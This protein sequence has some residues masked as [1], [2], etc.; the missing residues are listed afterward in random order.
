VIGLRTT[1][2]VLSVAIGV[3]A[4][5]AAHASVLYVDADGRGSRCS[6]TDPC[7]LTTGAGGAEP[8]DRVVLKRGR[9]KSN[10]F[11]VGPG[12]VLSGRGVRSPRIAV[13]GGYV[14]VTGSGAVLR[15]LRLDF[16]TRSGL[17]VS[18]AG[19]AE[20]LQIG[21]KALFACR[22]ETGAL[23]RDSVCWT[24]HVTGSAVFSWPES[25]DSLSWVR[26][27]TAISGYTGVWAHATDPDQEVV[28]DARN[29]I[30]RALWGGAALTEGIPSASARVDFASSN[31][32]TRYIS[33]GTGPRFVT[34]PGTAGNFTDPPAF[35][36]EDAGDFRQ[37]PGSP[38]VDRGTVDPLVGKV[39][40]GGGPRIQGTAPD[41]GAY[42]GVAR[43]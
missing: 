19:V 4:A 16:R 24:R 26:N 25:G 27:V 21:G 9:Y 10:G 11:A 31:Y 38:T 6:K 15:N 14:D 43:R 28:I 29:V 35:L 30:S 22:L 42:E 41:V 2:V 3:V 23:I 5:G 40:L 34:E 18:Q 1:L 8:G 37:A 17:R 20:R 33:S 32:A 12:V 7:G 36:D 39:A 13:A